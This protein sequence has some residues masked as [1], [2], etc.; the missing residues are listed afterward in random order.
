MQQ[1]RGIHFLA[2]L[3]LLAMV[4]GIP[5]R[6]TGG[7]KAFAV[8]PAGPEVKML[9]RI[10]RLAYYGKSNYEMWEFTSGAETVDNWTTLVTILNYPEATSLQRMDQLS[11]GLIKVYKSS[12]GQVLKAK[13]QQDAFGGVCNTIIVAFDEADAKRYELCF[14]KV[15]M[16]KSHAYAAIYGVRI[17]DLIDRHAKANAFLKENAIA[18]EQAMLSTRFPAT[19]SLPRQSF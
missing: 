9:N 11:E 17:P 4:S 19:E 10:Y 6:G 12:G 15:A 18:I 2:L 5:S 16:G 14:V 8:S 13:S 7:V 1:R 3:I